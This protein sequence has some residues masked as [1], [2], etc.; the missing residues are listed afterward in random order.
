[1]SA[2]RNAYKNCPPGS[3]EAVEKGCICFIKDNHEGRGVMM[4]EL[5]D[6]EGNPIY[7]I[8]TACPLHGDKNG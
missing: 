7:W 6:D 2:R 3:G 8:N 5:R 4:G 1:M